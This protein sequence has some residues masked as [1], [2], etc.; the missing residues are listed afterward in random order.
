MTEP[1][2]A[3][4]RMV[5]PYEKSIVLGGALTLF[6]VPESLVQGHARVIRTAME[7]AERRA[8]EEGKAAA[9]SAMRKAIGVTE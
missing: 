6:P 4:S 3:Y 7:R 5:R 2:F 8:F 9:Q 1:T